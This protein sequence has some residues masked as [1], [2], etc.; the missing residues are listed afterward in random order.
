D[1]I[2]R[3]W[4]EGNDVDWNRLWGSRRPGTTHLPTYPFA[5]ERCWF[6]RR[7]FGARDGVDAGGGMPSA[8]A[9]VQV[10]L[11]S[12]EQ[13]S[14]KKWLCFSERWSVS[15]SLDQ[16]IDWAGDGAGAAKRVVVVSSDEA[17][18]RELD[19]QMCQ[20]VSRE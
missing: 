16:P 8:D 9:A 4:I 3:A 15:P 10:D 13:D 6:P 2:G 7:G 19:D 20:I 1:R 17:D 12:I 5:R 14:G 11:A 18:C